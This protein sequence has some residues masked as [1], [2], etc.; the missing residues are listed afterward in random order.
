ML[1]QFL[2]PLREY[3]SALN[4]FRYIT[5]RTIYGSLTAFL[6]C[7]LLGPFVIR[8]L[9]R[10]QIGQIIQTDG[11]KSH[12][13][14]Q[15]TPTMGG[16][17]ILFSVFLSTILWGNISNHYVSIL[18]LT[19]LLF[20]FIGF[21]DD[22]LMQIK[23]RNMGF[24]AR[25]KFTIQV[26]FGLIIGFLIYKCPDFNTTL[27][28]PFFKDFS[29]DLGLYYIPFACLV[30][31]G[32]SNAVNLTDGLDGL[33]IG[34][35][36]VAS[37]TYMFFAYVAGHT[38]FAGYLHVRHIASAGEIT[39]ICGILAGAG[40]GFLWFNAHPAQVF[41]GDSGSIPLGAI[42][43]TIA[44]VTKQEILLLI[45]GGLFVIEA[46]SVIIQVSYFKI[47]K[48]KRVFRM[49]PLH[50]HFELKGWHES[51]VIV[52]FWIIAITLALISLSTLKIR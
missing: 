14:K 41:M 11:P 44:V 22:Y 39:V 43:G 23:K 32:T 46:M 8:Q 4:I 1:Y 6:I 47:S 25:G 35:Y 45:V 33:A 13:G 37:V 36:I 17:L 42:L 50:H 28:I 21:I 27:T 30:I 9:S 29:P 24:T 7:L 26:L 40:L 31:V 51:K 3:Y 2:Y 16:I 12:L 10:M 18:L 49:A 34:P 5:F 19:V 38:Q 15:G 52:R 20:G 48:G